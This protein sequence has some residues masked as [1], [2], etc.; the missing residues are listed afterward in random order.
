MPLHWSLQ[1]SWGRTELSR[2]PWLIAAFLL[3]LVSTGIAVADYKSVYLPLQELITPPGQART[4]AFISLHNRSRVINE[5]HL[6][7][8][9]LAAVLLCLPDNLTAA[10][11][12]PSC[13]E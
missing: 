1:L 11:K 12:R 9:L 10:A 6:T 8:A 4:Q 13:P 3:T 5:V 7:I 2:Q